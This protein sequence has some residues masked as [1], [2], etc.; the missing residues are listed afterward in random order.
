[1]I[2]IKRTN[3]NDVDFLGLVKQLDELL[4]I[5]DGEEHVF[6]AQLNKTDMIKQV[7]VAYD[8][9]EPVGCG[10]IRP[11]DDHIM[12]VKRMYVS[13]DKRG[14]G[15]ASKILHELENWSAELGIYQL[16]LETGLKQPEAIALY[17]K[18][19]Y[20]IIPNYGHYKDV[21]NSIC[22][23]KTLNQQP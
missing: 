12:E 15:I 3:S 4:M 22:F 10:A 20:N 14:K 16:I 18:S 7:V 2:T 21:G 1:M 11:Y 19:G 13:P 6:Y 9:D 23:G 8:G 17:Q 5:R